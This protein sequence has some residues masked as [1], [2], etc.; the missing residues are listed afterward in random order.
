MEYLYILDDSCFQVQ[1]AD[2]S[3]FPTSTPSNSS[4]ESPVAN[5]PLTA[6]EPSPRGL[7]SGLEMKKDA[8]VSIASVS[9]SLDLKQLP[10]MAAN[11]SLAQRRRAQ[12]RASQR[13]YRERKE[14]HLNDLET[15]LRACESE[16]LALIQQCAA[17]QKRCWRLERERQ[18]ASRND[19]GCTPD[20]ASNDLDR[21]LLKSGSSTPVEHDRP[22][23][24]RI[25]P[26]FSAAWEPSIY[27]TIM[28]F[29]QL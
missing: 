5:N 18:L 24:S 28:A 26:G 23:Q 16:K 21:P 27:E 14:K 12:N 15:Q 4:E 2:G 3:L 29:T 17:L 1:K 7:R 9:G 8:S 13:A 19:Q 10:G 11:I 20:L 25:E 6:T 22:L